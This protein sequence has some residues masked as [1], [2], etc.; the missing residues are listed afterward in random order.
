MFDNAFY[1]RCIN[2]SYGEFN[3]IY[4][5]AV[6][7]LNDAEV[8]FNFIYITTTLIHWLLDIIDKKQIITLVQGNDKNFYVD[9]AM[10]IIS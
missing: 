3:E 10:Q 8:K 7:Y 1:L 4:E 6:K 2:Y 5:L 9:Y